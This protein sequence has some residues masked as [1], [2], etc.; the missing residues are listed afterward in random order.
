MEPEKFKIVFITILIL[1]L[2]VMAFLII[3]YKKR[4]ADIEDN[5]F[6][7]KIGFLFL[8]IV[9][10]VFWFAGITIKTKIIM[11]QFCALIPL[12]QGLWCKIALFY[13]LGRNNAIL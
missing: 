5:K 10:S 2:I 13:R 9:V 6:Q 8:S 3:Y 11:L 4:G 7:L 1:S 12:F